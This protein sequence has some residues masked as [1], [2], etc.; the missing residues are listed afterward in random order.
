[1]KITVLMENMTYRRGFVCEHGLSVLVE[2]GTCRWLFDTGQTGLFMKNIQT[3]Q[4]DMKHLDGIILSHGHYDHCGGLKT[5]MGALNTKV[6]V[7]IRTEA[8]ERKYAEKGKKSPEEIG[9]PWKPEE[10][11]GL[12]RV[13]AHKTKIADHVWLVGNIPYTEGL[14]DPSVGML[15]IRDGSFVQDL[16]ADEQMLVIETE[17]G[18]AVFAGCSHPGI[19]N[20]LHYVREQFPDQEIYSVLAGMHLMHASDERIEMTVERIAEY[21]I[22]VLMPVHCTG[23]RG[24]VR[25]QQ[26]FPDS[27]RKAECGSVIEF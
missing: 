7:Y 25:L 18:L 19:L 13:T 22:H 23:V 26:A 10:C 11:P 21:G 4:M 12:V 16:M 24:I 27:F 1:M 3:L 5:L 20:C 2:D 8:F 9:I 14:E 15:I 6:P 17:K